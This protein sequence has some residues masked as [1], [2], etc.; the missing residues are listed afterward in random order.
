MAWLAA[1]STEGSDATWQVVADQL[2]ASLMSVWAGSPSNV[3]VVGGA[4]PGATPIVEHYDGTTWTKFALDASLVDI[5]LWWV[6]GFEDGQIFIGGEK[7]TL[8]RTT[9]GSSFDSMTPPRSDV[10]VFGIWG[11]ASNNVWAVGGT[12]ANA[13]FVWQY[14]G[15]H[16]TPFAG[17]PAGIGTCWKVNGLGADDVWISGSNNTLMH[18]TGTGTLDS[19][20]VPD[21]DMQQNNLFSI[22][23]N[24]KRV[25]SVGGSNQGVLYENDGAGW[26]TPL[27]SSAGL[28]IL[29]GVTVSENEVYAVGG[30]GEILR[31]ASAGQW[32]SEPSGTTQSL[33][34]PFIDPSGDVWAV[35]GHF[36]SNPTSNG[37]LLHKGAALN[38]SFQ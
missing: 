25:V 28:L 34:A 33:H 18:W 31:S 26:T 1:C 20:S 8:L 16:W 2:P 3:W 35:G 10:I 19:V 38:G 9:D 4:P 5:D 12:S 23:A 6:R 17:L 32:A 11:A 13:G 22:G 7:G 24:S 37:V 29:S 14:D 27:P 36:N 15:S 21:P 30:G